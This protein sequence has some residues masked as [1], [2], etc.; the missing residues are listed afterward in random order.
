MSRRPVLAV[1]HRAG[2]SLTELRRAAAAR[3][4]LIEADV[5]LYRGRLEVRHSKSIPLLPWLWD[6][7]YLEPKRASRLQ[8]PDVLAEIEPRA[9]LMLDLKGPHPGL[10][11]AV[12]GLL[13]ALDPVHE[14][15]VCTRHWWMLPSFAGLDHV[16]VVHSA[17][18]ARELARLR[19][20]LTRRPTFGVSMH[21]SLVSR[22][23]VAELHRHAEVVMTWPV[24]TPDELGD[25]LDLGVT[26]VISDYLEVLEPLL[27]GPGP[28]RG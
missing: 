25:V 12:A 5:H 27:D 9:P 13:R 24:S 4:D 7:W 19:R 3:V 1:A 11:P 20:R 2:N 16:R 6:R 22:D 8:L 23:V 28:V 21:R 26:G 14:V 15:T 10:A 18:N 17:R